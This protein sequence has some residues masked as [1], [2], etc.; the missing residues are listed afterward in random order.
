MKRAFLTGEDL[1]LLTA[2]Q[3]TG[4]HSSEVTSE[5]RK[6]AKA[7]NFGFLYEMGAWKFRS[8]AFENYGIDL[9]IEEAE[10]ARRRYFELFPG[11]H[12]WHDRQHRIAESLQ[13]VQSP[14]GRVR[15]LPDVLSSDSGVRA[16]AL[17][18]A[19]NSPVQGMANDLMLFS[20]V[21]LQNELDPRDCFMVMTLHDAVMLE[22]REDMVGEY[23]VACYLRGST[24]RYFISSPHVMSRVS[25]RGT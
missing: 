8:Y 6:R 16:E 15:H 12:S 7:V 11:L 4:K 3:L 13:Q 10:L 21:Q 14:L 9:S 23:A 25:H 18:Q 22:C 5:E 24:S 19:V 2:T 17:R 20:M 1:H